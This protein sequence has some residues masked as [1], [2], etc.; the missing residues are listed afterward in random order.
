[1]NL[2]QLLARRRENRRLMKTATGERLALRQRLDEVLAV[3]I[4]KLSRRA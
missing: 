1:M 3:L 4:C 2:T